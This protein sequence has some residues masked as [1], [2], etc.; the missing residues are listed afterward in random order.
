MADAIVIPAR[1]GSTR[2][3]GK[4]L[5]PIAGRIMLERVAGIAMLAARTLGGVEVLVATDDTR[6]AEA[7][8]ALG[9]RAAMTSPEISTGSGRALAAIRAAG[10]EPQ[11]IVN[12]QGDAP[13]TAPAHLIDILR[14]A[15]AARAAVATPVVQLSWPALDA[16]RQH[17]LTAPASGTTCIRDD[18]GRAVWFSKAILPFLRNEP[19]LREAL[20]LSPVLQHIGLYCY[21]RDALEAFEGAAPAPHETLEGLEQ[22]R[23]I[24]LGIPIDTVV[25]GPSPLQMGGIDSPAD[26]ER[27]ERMIREHGDPFVDW[28]AA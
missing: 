20:P 21:R 3:P 4:P 15:R 11:F 8:E 28:R 1:Y 25:V 18:D 10:A 5:L 27:A 13:F 14:H 9:L 7:A 17:K 26:L 22:L 23:L 12:L 19:R 16:L 2:L 6:I 24:A